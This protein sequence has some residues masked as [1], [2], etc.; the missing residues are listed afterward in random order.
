MDLGVLGGPWTLSTL[1]TLLLRRG[2]LIFSPVRP[3]FADF[4]LLIYIYHFS[5]SRFPDLT[6]SLWNDGVSCETVALF[7][8]GRTTYRAYESPVV[9]HLHD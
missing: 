2:P 7:T 9:R 5:T 1:P 4:Q 8:K 6:I 3:L